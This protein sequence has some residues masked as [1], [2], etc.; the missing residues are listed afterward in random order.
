MDGLWTKLLDQALGPSSWSTDGRWRRRAQNDARRVVFGILGQIAQ[1]VRNL[2]QIVQ[3]RRKVRLAAADD[4]I[5]ARQC[6]L[7]VGNGA[8][9]VRIGDQFLDLRYRGIG[10]SRQA[11]EGR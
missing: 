6:A 4:A 7:H 3:R 9:Q 2:A 10:V 8:W 1:V 5:D 11:L